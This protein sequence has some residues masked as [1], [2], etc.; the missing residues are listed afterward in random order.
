[1]G[2]QGAWGM[3]P[4]NTKE[5]RVANPRNPTTSGTQTVGKPKAHE[6]GKM[7]GPGGEAPMAG[8]LWGMSP[9][10]P[11]PLA[12]FPAREGG[13]FGGVLPAGGEVNPKNSGKPSAY[14]VG[15]TGGQ[16]GG[17]PMAGGCGGCPPRVLK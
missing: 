2:L 6:G 13:K 5:G 3:C 1:M 12:P 7:G 8:G 9:F 4:H 15:K 11:N 10:R 14:G 16:G 17:A